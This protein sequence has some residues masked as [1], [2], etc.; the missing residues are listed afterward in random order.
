MISC[1]EF[2]PLYSEL[3]R[4]MEE[5]LGREEVERFWNY[6]FAPSTEESVLSRNIR[7]EGIR[8]CYTYWAWSLNEEAADFTMSLNEKAGWFRIIMH[9]CPSKGR[10]LELEEKQ[11]IPPYR[12][13]CLHCDGYRH[14]IEKYGLKYIYDFSGTEKASCSILVYDPERFD[15]RIIVDENTEIMDRKASQNEYFHQEFHNSLNEGL[16]YLGS[17]YG[18]EALVRCLRGFTRSFYADTAE[19]I[20]ERGLATLQ[21]KIEDTYRKEHAPDAVETVL[22]DG[23]LRV[24][25]R[26]CPAVKYLKSTGR[27]VSKWHLYATSVVM[28]TLAADTGYEFVMEHYNEETGAASYHFLAK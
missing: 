26:Y 23:S 15:G 11:G 4:F 5:Q 21:E 12:D 27:T 18:E 28:E 19:A 9:R 14:S 10:L 6:L 7:K 13:Y 17:Y 24:C 16:N 1:T 20:R 3:F 2:I 8:G 22:E 25:V